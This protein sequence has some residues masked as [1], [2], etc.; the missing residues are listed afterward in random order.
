MGSGGFIDGAMLVG[1]VA[2]PFSVC[3]LGWLRNAAMCDGWTTDATRTDVPV[4]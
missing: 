2:A 1:T 4:I 3:F